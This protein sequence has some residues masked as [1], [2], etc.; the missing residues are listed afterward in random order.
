M[1]FPGD[2][3]NS[4]MQ[5]HD[6]T[7]THI[8]TAPAR[9]PDATVRWNDSKSWDHAK[10]AYQGTAKGEVLSFLEASPEGG[11][12]EA[13]AATRGPKEQL[14][15]AQMS[16]YLQRLLGYLPEPEDRRAAPATYEKNLA[17]HMAAPTQPLPSEHY[18]TRGAGDDMEMDLENLPQTEVPSTYEQAP[19]PPGNGYV[20]PL[21]QQPYATQGGGYA[22]PYPH[23]HGTQAAEVTVPRPVLPREYWVSQ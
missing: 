13:M 23:A 15:R 18:Q 1:S 10:M 11:G 12:G 2:E 8:H 5:I 22:G 6:D 16:E 9:A 4:A 19:A 21:Q 17:Y 3:D 14:P 20:H 7:E